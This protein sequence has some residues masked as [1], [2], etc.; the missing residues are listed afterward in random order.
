MSRYGVTY[1]GQDYY[2]ESTTGLGS[3]FDASPVIAWSYPKSYRDGR[4]NNYR[5]YF[6]SPLS[7]PAVDPDDTDKPDGTGNNIGAYPDASWGDPYFSRYLTDFYET[8][9][10]KISLDPT[11][12]SDFFYNLVTWRVPSGEWTGLRLVR[13][14][15][16]PP[17][18]VDDGVCVLFTESYTTQREFVEVRPQG[19]IS[20]YGVFIRL[21][22]GE[23]RSAGYAQAVNCR[24]HDGLEE[25]VNSVPR[26][27][28]SSTGGMLDAPDRDRGDLCRFLQGFG[29]EYDLWKTQADRLY[30]HPGNIPWAAAASWAKQF[31]LSDLDIY[32]IGERNL[33]KWLMAAASCY[34]QKG[35]MTG[36]TT[37][38]SAISGWPV[39][40]TVSPN[41]MLDTDD[42]SAEN[43]TGRWVVAGGQLDRIALG[44]SLASAVT[45]G[46]ITN[47]VPGSPHLQDY[48][49]RVVPSAGT[50]TLELGLD[51]VM[52]AVP[53]TVGTAY[54]MNLCWKALA[55]SGTLTVGYTWLKIDGTQIAGSTGSAATATTSWAQT[56]TVTTVAAPT[57]AAFLG[58][59]LTIAGSSTYYLDMMQ[60]TLSGGITAGTFSDARSVDLRIA[61]A[62][63]NLCLNPSFDIGTSGWTS[64]TQE[65]EGLL[66]VGATVF[67]LR[68]TA[69]TSTTTAPGSLKPRIPVTASVHVKPF[70]KGSWTWSSGTLVVTTQSAHGLV[71][72]AQVPL[73]FAAHPLSSRTYIVAS[74]TATTF[75]VAMATPGA[76][77]GTLTIGYADLNLPVTVECLNSAGTVLSTTQEVFVV[78]TDT[79]TRIGLTNHSCPEGTDK[80]RVKVAGSGT[81]GLLAS[82]GGGVDIDG[83]LIEVSD[84]VQSY[85]DATTYNNSGSSYWKGAAFVSESLLYPQRMA[86]QPVLARL[87]EDAVPDPVYVRVVP[88]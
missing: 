66:G 49:F 57:G 9:Y 68:A 54:A 81:S 17:E 52:H 55:A 67:C 34:Q 1:Y 44:P 25:F 82:S 45:Q 87:L 15:Y 37:L 80:V 12:G 22:G 35:T 83:C 51:D 36:L 69:E 28:T 79:W 84:V 10:G 18:T 32:T 16:G 78:D 46:L 88:V 13:R 73:V 56:A 74:P 5:P 50:A 70:F 63:T 33:R 75:T 64:G 3:D 65:P 8:T 19:D 14:Q 61:P 26:V 41:I 48:A 20:Y 7:P 53:V 60:V 4:D 29:F 72:G 11:L 24:N 77:S 38:A 23:W 27:Y 71:A 58:I 42:S 76:G 30:D 39:T 86:R 47:S 21:K 85:F 59:T 40:A 43:S 62:R 2:G 6:P 31:G